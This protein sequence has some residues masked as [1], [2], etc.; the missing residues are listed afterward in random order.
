MRLGRFGARALSLVGTGLVLASPVRVGGPVQGG[1]LPVDV[2][3]LASG[4]LIFRRGRS[5]VSGIVLEVDRG[6]FFSHAGLVWKTPAGAWVIHVSVAEVPGAPDVVR[7][8]PVTFF[9]SEDRAAAYAVLRHRGASQ[10]QLAAVVQAARRFAA[11][12]VPFDGALDL[13]TSDRLYCTELVWRAYREAGLDLAPQGFTSVSFLGIRRD[14]LTLSQLLANPDL[15][16]VAAYPDRAGTGSVSC[17]ARRG[18][19]QRGR[20]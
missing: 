12:A 1:T 6:S 9:L 3:R 8:D 17:S 5:L 13:A 4:D 19:S 15:E 14:Y 18:A 16:V 10:A 11:R 20:L 7:I 2:E